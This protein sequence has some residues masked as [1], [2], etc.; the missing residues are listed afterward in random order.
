MGVFPSPL[1]A[2]EVGH[3]DAQ[4]QFPDI[5]AVLEPEEGIQDSTQRPA[6]GPPQIN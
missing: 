5:S 2:R 4:E 3:V 1:S 6:P